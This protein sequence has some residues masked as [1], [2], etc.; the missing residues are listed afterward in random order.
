MDGH[1][2]SF[3]LGTI[4]TLGRIA[5]CDLHIDDDAI[6][7]RHCTLQAVGSEIL[8]ADLESANGTY[9]NELRVAH[10]RIVPGD[11]VQVGS[12]VLE[13]RV[14]SG[15][16]LPPADSL[17]MLSDAE[18]GTTVV[19]KQIDVGRVDWLEGVEDKAKDPLAR[20]QRYLTILHQVSDQLSRAP[21][22]E[23][24]FQSIVAAVLDVTSADRVALLLRRTPGDP[25]D[26]AAAE[27]RPGR[28][29]ATQFLVSHTVLNDVLNTGVSMCSQDAASD[30]RYAEGESIMAQ[31]IHSV[32]C[33]P[34][35]TTEAILG[36][37]YVDSRTPSEFG[38]SDLQLLAA[39]GNQAGVA[40]HRA[41]LLADL[42]Q[43]FL[44]MVKAIAATV[45]AK[46]GYTHRHSER[47]AT[48][49]VRIAQKMS[50]S[51]AECEVINL[52]GL[53]HDVGKIGV[54]DSILN[55]PGRL[56]PE[57]FAEIKK[58]PVHG[59][60]ILSNIQSP[61]VAA[62][63]PGVKYH[64]ERWNGAG[65]PEGLERENIPFLGRLLGVADFLDALTSARSYRGPMTLD[66][67]VDMIKAD[68]GIAFDPQIVEATVALH[69]VG[70][71]M[72]PREPSPDLT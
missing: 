24:L 8:L 71:L 31:Q 33:A 14:A 55:K 69:A 17:V 54:P 32:M 39:I 20:A 21:N 38:E 62:L 13:C 29:R 49:S 19:R 63:I 41:R 61:R 12:T 66:Q 46:D 56:T 60:R 68:S 7:R 36:A 42:E 67:A 44:D 53:L 65:Y 30:V 23:V 4:I 64:H 22:V 52:S 11:R 48:I 28:S 47:V 10:A 57:E 40:L 37:L 70:S 6:S 25:V 27:V 58:H 51:S 50:R 18:L 45:D 5:D 72:L 59:V 43:L 2:V 3:A 34:L 1:V 26:I 9:V 15:L 16:S 35:R